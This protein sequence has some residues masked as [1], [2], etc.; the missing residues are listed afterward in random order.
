MSGA[1]PPGRPFRYLLLWQAVVIH[2]WV[3]V[4]SAGF[5]VEHV[6]LLVKLLHNAAEQAH[7]LW[8]LILMSQTGTDSCMLVQR[9]GEFTKLAYSSCFM[10]VISP[11]LPGAV[12][13]DTTSPHVCMKTVLFKG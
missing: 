3:C 1:S 13:Q 2:V 6:S 9:W 7:L 8:E 5:K 10:K 12:L 4:L 11:H